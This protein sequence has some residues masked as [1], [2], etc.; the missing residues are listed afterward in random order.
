MGSNILFI[1][2]FVPCNCAFGATSSRF[3][4]YVHSPY[5]VHTGSTFHPVLNRP[6]ISDSASLM[7]LLGLSNYDYIILFTIL[8]CNHIQ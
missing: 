7:S 5:W 1:G 6:V 3:C 2:K 8:Y 4:L